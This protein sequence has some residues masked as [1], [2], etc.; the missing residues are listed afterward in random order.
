MENGVHR[1][2]LQRTESRVTPVAS[3][4]LQERITEGSDGISHKPFPPVLPYSCY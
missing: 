4:N 2:A 1:L 3:Q